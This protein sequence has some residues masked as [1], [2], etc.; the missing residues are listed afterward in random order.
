MSQNMKDEMQSA[1]KGHYSR[2]TQLVQYPVVIPLA[3]KVLVMTLPR[4]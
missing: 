3:G 4:N 1:L 2:E